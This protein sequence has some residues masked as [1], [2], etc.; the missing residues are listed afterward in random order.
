MK[1]SCRINGLLHINKSNFKKNHKK[2]I[3]MRSNKKYHIV[4]TVPIAN[5]K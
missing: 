5:R 1:L 3:K 4:G 2:I